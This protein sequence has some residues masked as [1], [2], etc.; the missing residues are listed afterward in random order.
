MKKQFLTYEQQL[1]KLSQEKELLINDYSFAS[2]S[3]E[4]LSYF[5]LIGG[6]KELFKH[7]PSGKYLR[8]V[9]F[10]E[11]VSFYYFDEQLRTLFLKYILHVERHL[12]SM[13]SYYFCEKYGENQK[14]Y[15]TPA[16]F[17]SAKKNQR[18]VN[19]LIQILT[20]TVTLP[21]HYRYITHAIN[22]HNNVPLW[23]TVNA[24]TLGQVS[25]FYQYMDNDLQVKISK[26]FPEYSE[27]QLHQFITMIAKCRNVCAHGERLYNF[28]TKDTIPDTVLHN[29]LSISSKNGQYTMGKHDLFAVVIS[30]R[31]LISNSDFKEFK[32]AL[33]RLISSTLKA[34]PHISKETLLSEMGFPSNWNKIIRFKK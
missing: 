20:K 33:S 30:L 4:E 8:G 11:I 27:K 6:Y 5:S 18:A 31:Y 19:K 26:N 17:N 3:L 7:K 10:E 22:K 12:K 1:N 23:V 2:K 14:E 24:M 32:A 29:K 28:H 21:S 34:C 9:T 13:I 25:A 16:H 15:L